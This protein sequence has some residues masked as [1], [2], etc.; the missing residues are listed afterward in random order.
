MLQ[1]WL[2][3]AVG[4]G[5]QHHQE[6]YMFPKSVVKSRDGQELICA[7]LYEAQ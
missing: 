7:T 2:A 5:V 1:V 3:E 6:D 4:T